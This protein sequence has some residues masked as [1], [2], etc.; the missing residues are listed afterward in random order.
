MTDPIDPEI[1]EIDEEE[2][3]EEESLEDIYEEIS[4]QHSIPVEMCEAYFDNQHHY[5]NEALAS[6]IVDDTYGYWESEEEFAQDL[7][8]SM[9]DFRN[10][11]W[12][13]YIDFKNMAEDMFMTD[14]YSFP[15][16]GGIWVFR[17]S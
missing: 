1:D 9:V 12:A 7:F 8:E 13:C 16:M 4:R 2:E 15:F 11:W 6:S 17:N 3:V 14:Y 10:E 5:D